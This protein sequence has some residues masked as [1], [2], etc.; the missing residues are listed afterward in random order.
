MIICDTRKQKNQRILQYF[1][2][3]NIPYIEQALKTGDYMNPDRT[4][5]VIERKKDLGELLK[6]MCSP[7]KRR[8]RDEIRRARNEGIRFIVLCEHGGNYKE[9]KDVSQYKSKHSKVSGRTLMN[10]MYRA[11]IAYGV[12]FLFC[13]KRS[14]G[15]IIAEILGRGT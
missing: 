8:F 15:R 14:T 10:E 6:N 4:D 2:D 7:D 11:Q 12:E 13:D 3:H 1:E 9:L 5:I